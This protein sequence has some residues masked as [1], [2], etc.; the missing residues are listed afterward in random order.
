MGGEY[1]D[2]RRDCG[3]Y[4]RWPFEYVR[5]FQSM[6]TSQS[7][8]PDSAEAPDRRHKG[9]TP[10]ASRM[11]LSLSRPA[12]QALPLLAA[13]PSQSR[14][15]TKARPTIGLTVAIGDQH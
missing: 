12:E 6:L 9:S 15:L 3:S 4:D 10:I 1:L 2:V 14:A 7:N 8:S 11:G 13:I 5:R